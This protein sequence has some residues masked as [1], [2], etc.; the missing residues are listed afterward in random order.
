MSEISDSLKIQI[1]YTELPKQCG[2][3]VF[4][5]LDSTTD[6]FGHGD[7]C[8]RNP[9]I[10]FSVVPTAVCNNWMKAPNA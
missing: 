2:N 9:D 7:V 8:I 5:K 1:G 6:N 3:C 10:T 4:I